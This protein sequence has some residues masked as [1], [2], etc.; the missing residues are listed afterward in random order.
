[1][2][3]MPWKLAVNTVPNQC[4]T[5]AALSN[6]DQMPEL[7]IVPMSAIHADVGV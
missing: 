4:M 3:Q 6:R 7:S 1:M 5:I 2:F